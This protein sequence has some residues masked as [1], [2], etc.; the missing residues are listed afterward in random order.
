MAS[1]LNEFLVHISNR[2]L[3]WNGRDVE[4]RPTSSQRLEKLMELRVALVNLEI[5]CVVLSLTSAS[6]TLIWY[7]I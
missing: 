6:N 2:F 7:S 4:S 5:A 3:R 1:L